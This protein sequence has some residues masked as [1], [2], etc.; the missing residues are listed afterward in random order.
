MRLNAR[1][2]LIVGQPGSGKTTLARL[3]FE[4]A[5]H[6]IAIDPLG[7]FSPD[8]I[9]GFSAGA[10]AIWETRDEPV[11]LSIAPT[12]D[13][14]SE[15]EHLLIILEHAQRKAIDDGTAGHIAVI[16][17]EASMVSETH[18][19]LP[20]MRRIYNLGRRWGVCLVVIAQV[21]T[22]IHR[23]TRR[24][25]QLIVAMRQLAVSSDLR[26]MFDVD[27]LSELDP[28]TPGQRPVYGTH[29]LTAPPDVEIERYWAE[30]LQ[31]PL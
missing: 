20:Q 16:L 13:P 17:D 15:V 29:Y 23:L 18:E 31:R 1:N 6:V 28:L 26:R 4:Q 10:R 27:H 22:D 5:P 2:T 30:T 12:M 11:K 21:D 25:S 14:E 7:E 9:E 8:P 24:N 19:I 3:L